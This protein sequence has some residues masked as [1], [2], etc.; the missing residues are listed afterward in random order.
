MKNSTECQGN[1]IILPEVYT[2]AVFGSRRLDG[3]KNDLRN[4]IKMNENK[5]Y[6]NLYRFAINAT[7]ISK[8]DNKITSSWNTT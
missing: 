4:I 6:L 5:K 7:E 2:I 8:L 1:N 3:P